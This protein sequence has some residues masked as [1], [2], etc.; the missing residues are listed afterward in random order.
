MRNRYRDP[1]A[2]D[3]TPADNHGTKNS[4]NSDRVHAVE[5][6]AVIEGRVG[7]VDRTIGSMEVVIKI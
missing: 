6:T 2:V 5:F 4:D 1:F 7:D 3:W